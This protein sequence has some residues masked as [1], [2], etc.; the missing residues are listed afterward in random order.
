MKYKPHSLALMFP[1]A[2]AEDS[3][4]ISDDIVRY[5]CRVPIVLFEGKILDGMTR[6][7]ICIKYRIKPLVRQF[8]GT[9]EDAIAHVSSL[10]LCRR[11]LSQ[12]QKAAIAVKLKALL[13]HNGM[14]KTEA[15][16]EASRE[17]KVSVGSVR[18]MDRIAEARP[19]TARKVLD[20]RKSI[21]EAERELNP[22]TASTQARSRLLSA[23]ASLRRLLLYDLPADVESQTRQAVQSIDK[24]LGS[25]WFTKKFTTDQA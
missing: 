11:H 4:R 1:R 22:P 14:S 23:Q 21:A 20:G 3:K 12:S 17:T 8:T 18:R 13:E 24:A 9:H 2:G 5:G 10:N 7:D 15:L 6:Y 25:E 19:R 16:L